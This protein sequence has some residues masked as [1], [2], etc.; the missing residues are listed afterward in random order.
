MPRTLA[1]NIAVTDA[2]SMRQQVVKI[3]S[4]LVLSFTAN[5]DTTTRILN[6]VR[7]KL[8]TAV[9]ASSSTRLAFKYPTPGPNTPLQASRRQNSQ[10][11]LVSV[12]A[13]ASFTKQNTATDRTP[14]KSREYLMTRLSMMMLKASAA[15]METAM[16]LEWIIL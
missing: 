10:K 15:A 16:K 8:Y 12:F 14:T 5:T 3:P 2:V 7:I 9:R 13:P 6:G 1:T 11:A 4:R